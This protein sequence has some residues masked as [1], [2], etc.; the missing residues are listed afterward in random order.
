MANPAPPDPPETPERRL[1][2]PGGLSARL[3]LLTVVL[4]AAEA[5]AVRPSE[6]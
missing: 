3:L 5:L 1:Y 6:A 2:V 4:R